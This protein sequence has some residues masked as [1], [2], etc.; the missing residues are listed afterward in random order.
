MDYAGYA[1]KDIE[2]YLKNIRHHY[3]GMLGVAPSG[4][5][6]RG[7]TEHLHQI[8]V[9]ARRLRNALSIYKDLFL[10]RQLKQWNKSIRRAVEVS[11]RARDLDV[12]IH[13]L[14]VYAPPLVP[15]FGRASPFG[16][17]LAAR[18]A[19]RAKREGGGKP[20]GI[21]E[22]GALVFFIAALKKKRK[23]LQPRIIRALDNL[24]TRD[25][26]GDIIRSLGRAL[27]A[28]R[29]PSGGK[30]EN[31]PRKIYKVARKKLLHRVKK[32][33][34]FEPF[35]YQPRRVR[36]LHQMRIAAKH[37]RY[38]LEGFAPVYGPRLPLLI[39]RVVSFHRQ[40]GDIHDHDV[41]T[42]HLARYARA[43]P[44][45]RHEEAVLSKVKRR[46]LDLR[47]KTY[48]A[49][50]RNW[51]RAREGRFFEDLLEYVYAH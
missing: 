30:K 25:T 2:I 47:Q 27:A 36:G 9:N 20:R 26:L 19:S 6:S 42:Q 35:V 48:C 13:F 16:G 24:N 29:L 51:S 46:C 1:K 39:A 14:N 44:R 5:S 33:M 18:L 40:L 41:W 32:L 45:N 50:V 31:N 12:Y 34:A 4:V 21:S 11:S 7:A 3:R 15:P 49:F 10:P 38:T 23:E 22:R 43:R 28:D 8:R 37:L 17:R